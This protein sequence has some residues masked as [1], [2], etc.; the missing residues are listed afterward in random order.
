MQQQFL[1]LTT[2]NSQDKPFQVQATGMRYQIT[3]QSHWPPPHMVSVT[4]PEWQWHTQAINGTAHPHWLSTNRTG[5]KWPLLQWKA[6]CRRRERHGPVLKHLAAEWGMAEKR[7]P[8][9]EEGNDTGV[10]GDAF[11]GVCVCGGWVWHQ[12]FPSFLDLCDLM[13]EDNIN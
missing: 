8:F 11:Y 13:Q 10:R 3:R 5:P 12:Q 1:A 4:T 7:K 2:Q 9:E 6:D